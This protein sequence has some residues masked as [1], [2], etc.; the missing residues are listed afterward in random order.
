MEKRFFKVKALMEVKSGKSQNGN[1]W[2]TREVVLEA[3]EKVM[4]PDVIVASLFGDAVDK[5][6]FKENA[7]L[8]AEFAFRAHEYQGRWF[9]YLRISNFG[10][11]NRSF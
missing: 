4:Y 6:E 11:D 3:D 1:D 9:N 10:E 7:T 2:K 5:F 8:W